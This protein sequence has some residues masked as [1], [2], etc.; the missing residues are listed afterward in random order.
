[1]P[2]ML[3]KLLEL[4]PLQPC[5]DALVPHGVRIRRA[6]PWEAGKVREFIGTHFGQGWVEE[7]SLGFSRQP[8]SLFLALHEKRIIGFAAYECTRRNMFGPTGVA[9]EFRGKGAGRALLL[10][11]LHAWRE[12][13]YVYGVIGGAGPV[14]F[15]ARH[16]GATVI[17]GSEP[18][19][20]GDML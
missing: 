2:D 4:P 11:S 1:M 12:M 6:D 14:D 15:Y 10:A 5:L 3:V 13:G 9:E 20:Y 16:C 17:P 8:I 7:A 19:I 18:G